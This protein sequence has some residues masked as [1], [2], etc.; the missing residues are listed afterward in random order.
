[1]NA[2]ALGHPFSFR[3]ATLIVTLAILSIGCPGFGSEELGDDFARLPDNPTWEDVSPVFDA[4]CNDCH[5]VPAQE[6]AP[7]GFRYDRCEDTENE[8]GASS[9]AERAKVRTVDALPS[10]MPPVTYSPQPTPADVELLRRWV[11]NGG[12]CIGGGS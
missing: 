12:P 6:G 11:E 3:V 10:P 4:Y 9:Y 1:M 8:L 5:S 2:P 7:G